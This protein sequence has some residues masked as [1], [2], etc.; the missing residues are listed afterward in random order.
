[1]EVSP[2]ILSKDE[3]ILETQ[4]S[5]ESPQPHIEVHDKEMEEEEDVAGEEMEEEDKDLNEDALRAYHKVDS[6]KT[7]ASLRMKPEHLFRLQIP[8]C[9][10]VS[11]PMVRS[12]LGC[13]LQKLEQEFTTGYREGAAVFYVTTTNE[14]GE[15]S[16]FTEEEMEAW[17]PFWKKRNDIFNAQVE[18][19]PE[20]R[21]LKNLKFFVC[22]GNHRLLA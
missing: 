11:M 3:T 5:D 6:V 15:S 1:M 7:I 9:R 8:L 22:D 14:A 20:L 4:I 18:S 13:D 12:T 16:T 17:D 2:P 10:M 19:S 21:F